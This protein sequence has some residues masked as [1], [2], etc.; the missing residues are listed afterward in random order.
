MTGKQPASGV[1]SVSSTPVATS[2]P[3]TPR[4]KS[5]KVQKEEVHGNENEGYARSWPPED[6]YKLAL[7]MLQ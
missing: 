3:D 7:N 4:R 1:S 6:D 5:S 2:S